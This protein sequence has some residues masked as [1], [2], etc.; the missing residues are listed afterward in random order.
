M[1]GLL[2]LIAML[3]SLGGGVW[4]E[5]F[6][7]AA[8]YLDLVSANS[9]Q[10]VGGVLL[11]LVNCIAVVGIAAYMYPIIKEMS[12]ASAMGYAGFRFIE[13]AILASAALS[14]LLLI[15]VSD[16]FLPAGAGAAEAFLALGTVI[17]AA[18]ASLT[19]LL[20]AIFFSC[21]ALILYTFLYQTR[22]VPRFISI[23]GF[24]AVPLML[25]WNL[26]EAF[27]ISISF[28]LVFGLLIIL[29]EIFLGFWLIIKGFNSPVEALERV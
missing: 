4:L 26:L 5:T 6:L 3:T 13:A 21:G 16:E 2:F 12:G 25:I 24:I 1:V 28:G 8:D 19:G 15:A 29:N 18:R 27:G 10:V 9:S 17:S 22:L 14:P 7:G 20:T 23:W 11:E